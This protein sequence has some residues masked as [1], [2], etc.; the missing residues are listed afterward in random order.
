[1]TGFLGGY[2]LWV[3]S[4]KLVFVIFWMAG[5]FA[6]G[7]YVVYHR[8][9][10]PGSP[11]DELWTERTARLRRVIVSP[12]MIIAWVLGIALVV[13]IGLAGQGWLHAKLLFLLLLTGWYG[14]AVSTSKKLSRG[15]RPYSSRTLR[16]LNE[17]PALAIILIVPLG[18]M[19]PF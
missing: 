17:A 10:D 4:A 9:C 2:T 3:L 18:L 12:S 13:N 15:A 7:R 5:L 14:W 11:E 16:I 8:E 19:K 1:M 6:L